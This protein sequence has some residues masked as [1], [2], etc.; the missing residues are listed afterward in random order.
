[1][2]TAPQNLINTVGAIGK[3][4]RDRSEQIA[5]ETRLLQNPINPVGAIGVG[6]IGKAGR[7]GSDQIAAE[8]RLLQ[9][10]INPV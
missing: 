4:G 8:T 1:M 6:A 2:D 10:P 5:A 7:D 3:A 9:N